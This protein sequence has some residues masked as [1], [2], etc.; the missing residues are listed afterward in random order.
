[1]DPKE[2]HG[3]AVEE[4]FDSTHGDRECLEPISTEFAVCA[5]FCDVP[6]VLGDVHPG[7]GGWFSEENVVEHAEF[8]WCVG[9]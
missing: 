4:A 7:E 2:E 9:L 3:D 5:V 6:T 8:V 1:M